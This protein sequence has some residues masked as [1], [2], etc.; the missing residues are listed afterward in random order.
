MRYA[1]EIRAIEI[2]GRPK[3][4]RA[5]ITD[6]SNGDS[7]SHVMALE[8]ESLSDLARSMAIAI[9]DRESGKK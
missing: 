5:A 1:I 3:F 2:T 8:N 9:N 4:F 6:E 7:M